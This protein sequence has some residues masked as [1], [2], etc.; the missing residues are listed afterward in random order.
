MFTKSLG[1]MLYVDDVAKEK[2][3][4]QSIGCRI[5][6]ETQL[7]GYTTFDMRIHED[8]TVMFTV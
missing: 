3:F 8:S 2:Q 6:N 4:W 1:L 7:M 5:L